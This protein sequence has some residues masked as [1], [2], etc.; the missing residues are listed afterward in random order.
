VPA[1]ATALSFGLNLAAT[2]SLTTDDYTMS[3]T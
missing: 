3:G 2:G 1:G